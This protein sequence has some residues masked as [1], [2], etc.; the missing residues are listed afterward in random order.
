MRKRKEA[1]ELCKCDNP[2]S[3]NSFVY[4]RV[5]S[6]SRS[7]CC[8]LCVDG[9]SRSACHIIRWAEVAGLIETLLQRFM[10]SLAH[11]YELCCEC[12]F[13][14]LNGWPVGRSVGWRLCLADKQQF[15]N[16]WCQLTMVIGACLSTEMECVVTTHYCAHYVYYY[17]VHR[18]IIGMR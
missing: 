17:R 15:I 2:R 5:H 8:R 10:H 14:R 6:S 9:R 3:Y 11:L 13:L 18:Q 7:R 4:W 1:K 16:I 12:A